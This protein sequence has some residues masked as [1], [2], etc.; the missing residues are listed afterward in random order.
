[1]KRIKNSFTVEGRG[2]HTGKPS[3]VV[4]Y[5]V[6]LMGY[7]FSKNG[8]RLIANSNSVVDVVRGTSIK[9]GFTVY[10]VEHVLSALYGLGVM[11]AGIE[12]T[13]EEPPVCDGS[14][15]EFVKKILDAGIED[16]GVIEFYSVR[17][18]IEYRSNDTLITIEPYDRLQIKCE[19]EF[20]NKLIGRQ[21]I[22]LELTSD[23]YIKEVAPARTFCFDYEVEAIKKIGLGKGGN[24]KNTIVV[25]LN[26][27]LVEGGLR[28]KDEFVRHKL[29]DFIGDLALSGKRILGRIYAYRPGHGHNINFLKILEKNIVRVA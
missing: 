25:G 6:D 14:S 20:Q 19:I 26:K 2:L 23:N 3:K 5:P 8:M 1:M 17:E 13:S 9:D 22:E 21:S 18:K 27:I 15:I 11:S 10:T 28:F 29:L 7:V 4:F 16:D 24:L 12:I